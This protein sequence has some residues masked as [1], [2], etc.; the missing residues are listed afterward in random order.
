M[1]KKLNFQSAVTLLIIS[2]IALYKKASPWQLLGGALHGELPIFHHI[3]LTK[4]LNCYRYP[5]DGYQVR[6][7]HLPV[8]PHGRAPGSPSAGGRATDGLPYPK[9]QG[10]PELPQVLPCH[11]GSEAYRQQSKSSFF[12]LSCLSLLY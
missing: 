6:A 7:A 9:I 3:I 11:Q 4:C 2:S 1:Q 8:T 10:C 5:S 12:S